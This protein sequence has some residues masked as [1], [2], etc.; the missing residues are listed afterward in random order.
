MEPGEFPWQKEIWDLFYTQISKKFEER[1]E[2]IHPEEAF[3]YGFAV[4][5][6]HNVLI[7]A[8]WRPDE[9]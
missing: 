2:D 4:G 1:G 3:A 8:K 5:V 9:G 7:N 6:L